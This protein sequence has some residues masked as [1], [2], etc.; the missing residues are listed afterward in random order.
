M[1]ILVVGASGTIGR[2][3]ADALSKSNEVIRASSKTSPTKVD[4]A[5]PNSIHGM[6]RALG[7]VDH[8][9]CCAG[10]AKFAPL[11]QLTEDDFE[12]CLHHK[13][14]GQ[15]NLIRLGFDH[16]N[17]G[18]SFTVT[19]GIL[20]HTPMQGG[21]AISL[22]NAGLEGFVRGAALEAPR[23]IRV[24]AVSPPWV[25]ETLIAFKMDPSAGVPA[26]QVAKTYVKA[27]E[28]EDT[29]QTFAVK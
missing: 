15:V 14:M 27:V 1:R 18:G 24:N 3:V 20:S 5:N 8:V 29:G 12:F 7:R 13:L 26:A 28:G 25:T 16:V 4:I 6:Y 17:D 19:S 10:N 23:G 2:A 22:V 9:V 21:A 11:D